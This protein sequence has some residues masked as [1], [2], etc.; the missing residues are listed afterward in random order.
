MSTHRSYNFL[1]ITYFLIVASA[2]TKKNNT[3]YI[4]PSGNSKLYFSFIANNSLEDIWLAKNRDTSVTIYCSVT[5]FGTDNFF[6]VS[7]TLPAFATVTPQ[8]IPVNLPRDSSVTHSFT[9]HFHPT[10]T[11][12]FPI[13]VIVSPVHVGKD[14]AAYKCSVIVF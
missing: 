11:G 9:F 8:T 7:G 10:D 4:P 3:Q 2:C 12:T 1:L 13:E 14:S 5:N 6:L